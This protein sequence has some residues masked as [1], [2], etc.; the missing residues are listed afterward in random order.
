MEGGFLIEHSFGKHGS[1]SVNY[2]LRR[3][4]HQWGSLNVNAP[5]PG[6]GVRP[7]GGSQNV[8]QYASEGVIT[9]HQLAGNAILNAGKRMSLWAF[10]VASHVEGDA[11]GPDSFATNSYDLR[12]DRGPYPGSSPG[13]FFA[14]TNTHPG[15]DTT[16]SLFAGARA[17]SYFNITTGQDNNGDSIYNDRPA[18]ATDLTRSSVVRTR[19]GNFDTDPM[20]GQ[21]IVPMNYAQAPGVAVVML[22]ASKDFH[23]G[24]RAAAP[25]PPAG[26]A[27]AKPGEK[28]VL[29]PPRYRLQVGVWVDNLLN[30]VNPGPPVGV[31]TSPLFGKSISLNPIFTGNSAANRTLTLHAAFYF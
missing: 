25:L 5:L 3:V 16:V 31:L 30:H 24:P 13:Q 6:T 18:F 11:F 17:H 9:S 21:T 1:M 22:S 27:P 10:A 8:Y 19:Y 20:P 2:L 15:W 23:F 28:A 14:G 12:A 26:H 4:T 7:L 29:P